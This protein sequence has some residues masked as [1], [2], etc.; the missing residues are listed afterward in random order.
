[1]KFAARVPPRPV[2]TPPPPG[3]LSR[4]PRRPRRRRSDDDPA[5]D[6]VLSPPSTSSAAAAAAATSRAPSLDPLAVPVLFTA[7]C[8]RCAMGRMCRYN[9]CLAVVT[10]ISSAISLVCLCIGLSTDSWLYTCERLSEEGVPG[11]N[12]TYRNTTTGLWRKC[13][14]DGTIAS[15]IHNNV[16]FCFVFVPPS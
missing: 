11:H 7:R 4:P 5:P 14:D 9:E 6:A 2:S 10:G 13:V 8:E 15:I 1:V 12:V 16:C 3:S